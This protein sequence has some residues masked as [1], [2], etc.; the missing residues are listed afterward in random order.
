MPHD[1]HRKTPF[2]AILSFDCVQ[3]LHIIVFPLLAFFLVCVYNKACSK[4]G[5]VILGSPGITTISENCPIQ[6]K[7]SAAYTGIGA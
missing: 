3:S 7:T 5:V 1:T 2:N 4:P 6:L